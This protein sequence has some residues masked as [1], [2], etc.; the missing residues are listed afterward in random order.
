[1]ICL[2]VRNDL[3]D[4]KQRYV[5]QQ[6]IFLGFGLTNIVTGCTFIKLVF[7]VSIGHYKT[8]ALCCEI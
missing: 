5:H 2:F 1:M 3:L 7:W 4:I 8:V 6:F